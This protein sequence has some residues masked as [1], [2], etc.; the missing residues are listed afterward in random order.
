MWLGSLVPLVADIANGRF[1]FEA[2]T[3]STGYQLYFPAYDVYLK[4][5]DKY[6]IQLFHAPL[7]ESMELLSLHKYCFRLQR[8][9]PTLFLVL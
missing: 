5:I 9:F 1:T 8:A 4:E 7:L 3:A 2:L 6:W